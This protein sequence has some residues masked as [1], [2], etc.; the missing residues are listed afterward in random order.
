MSNQGSSNQKGQKSD[1]K[2][3]GTAKQA[4]KKGQQTKP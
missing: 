2:K 4:T 3:S 1:Q